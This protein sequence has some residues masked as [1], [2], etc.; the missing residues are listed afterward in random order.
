MVIPLSSSP[1]G[2]FCPGNSNRERK[3]C[4]MHGKRLAVRRRPAA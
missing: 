4:R 2:M 1:L 3:S